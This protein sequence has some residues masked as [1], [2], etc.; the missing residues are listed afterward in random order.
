[1]N[2]IIRKLTI[3]QQK[4]VFSFL[5]SIYIIVDTYNED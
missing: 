5:K 4:Y 1:M 2:I 3:Y